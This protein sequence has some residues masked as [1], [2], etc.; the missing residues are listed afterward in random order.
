MTLNE[1]AYTALGVANYLDIF[2]LC[3]S[4]EM[5]HQ[6]ACQFRLIDVGRETRRKV[7][8]GGAY[9]CATRL[10]TKTLASWGSL[11]V[12]GAADM[13]AGGRKDAKWVEKAA[14]AISHHLLGKIHVLRRAESNDRGESGVVC[15]LSCQ[16]PHG[17]PL[18][19][20][21]MRP[22]KRVRAHDPRK[23]AE[24]EDDALV[25]AR[26]IPRVAR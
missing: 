15:L 18:F 2:Y 14:A 7:S 8:N 1:G 17:A 3:M 23:C 13:A 4:T 9:R 16:R 11:A 25:L 19:S 20:D 26:H 12:S 24:L 5:V 6:E 22:P 10:P 21:Y